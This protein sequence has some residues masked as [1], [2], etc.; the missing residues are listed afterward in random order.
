MQIK[1]IRYAHQNRKQ[2]RLVLARLLGLTAYS[3]SWDSVLF[4][5][6]SDMVTYLVVMM[7]IRINWNPFPAFPFKICR[8]EVVLRRP[9]QPVDRDRDEILL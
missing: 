5:I 2:W 8:K 6:L 1:A 9:I 7:M 3:V 4:L